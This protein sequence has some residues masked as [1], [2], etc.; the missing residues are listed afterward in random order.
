M[1]D[2]AID[3]PPQRKTGAVASVE[4]KS[5]K[6]SAI[7]RLAP[8]AT[9]EEFKQKVGRLVTFNQITDGIA[10]LKHVTVR[11]FPSKDYDP[12]ATAEVDLAQGVSLERRRDLSAYLR[13]FNI[14]T[15]A[16]VKSASAIAETLARLHKSRYV[17][18]DNKPDGVFIT[19]QGE[20]TFVDTDQMT[21]VPDVIKAWT[22]ETDPD[23]GL[24]DT[25]VNLFTAGAHRGGLS[26]GHTTD[27]LHK[28]TPLGL[29]KIFESIGQLST[30]EEFARKVFLWNTSEEAYQQI[31]ESEDAR[32]PIVTA[33][34]Q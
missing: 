9:Y 18:V 8:G 26:I 33:L 4:L 31:G 11:R 10:G 24:G 21:M 12:A 27:E 15:F 30:A 14:D 3:M 5:D 6:G 29:G 34:S 25:L 1:R 17:L 23:N 7:W 2:L 20:V 19:D 28:V 16:K 22:V 13:F 32:E